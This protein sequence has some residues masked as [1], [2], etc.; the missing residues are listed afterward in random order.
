[1]KTEQLLRTLGDARTLQI[2]QVLRQGHSLAVEDVQQDMTRKE[3]YSRMAKLK[4]VGLI[5]KNKGYHIT[6]LGKLVANKIIDV[7]G[8]LCK[9]HW[10]LKAVDALLTPEEIP[11]EE[12]DRMIALL[13]KDRD[14]QKVLK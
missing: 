10:T 11:R 14:M 9:N 1:M 2:F 13:V 7:A 3:F 4:A 12:L 8:E 5:R 6:A